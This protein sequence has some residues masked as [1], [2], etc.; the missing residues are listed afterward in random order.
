M[1]VP[2][3]EANAVS[4]RS[5]AA[6][7]DIVELEALNAPPNTYDAQTLAALPET[8][9]QVSDTVAFARS[10]AMD[11]NIEETQERAKERGWQTWRIA[12][13]DLGFYSASEA[14]DDRRDI[15]LS[16]LVLVFLLVLVLL[17]FAVVHTFAPSLQENHCSFKCIKCIPLTLTVITFVVVLLMFIVMTASYLFAVASANVC[18]EPDEIALDLV[19]QDPESTAAFYVLVLCQLASSHTC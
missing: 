3:R 19:D 15:L 14:N 1:Y 2:V 18:I 9:R 13:S 4:E 8:L 6:Q 11:F 17:A 10:Y 7:Q 5:D 12:Y 16:V